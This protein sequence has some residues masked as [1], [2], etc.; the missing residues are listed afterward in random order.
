MFTSVFSRFFS[1]FFAALALALG[2]FVVNIPPAL[3]VTGDMLYLTT[4]E[5]SGAYV[6]IG[7]PIIN[8]G[9][10][11]FQAEASAEGM[12]P[13][14][15]RGKLSSATAALPITANT[16]LLVVVTFN[17]IINAARL[18]ELTNAMQTRPDT[19][20]VI[21]SDGCCQVASNLQKLT[22]VA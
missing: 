5:S 7:T 8:N 20:I 11:A 2:F 12:T 10:T 4:D 19:A 17:G 21:F 13:I 1:R 6:S 14:D 15:G 9:W 18:A 3:A 16:K 22:Q